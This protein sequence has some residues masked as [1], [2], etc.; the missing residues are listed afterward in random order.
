[1]MLFDP[2]RAE[3]RDFNALIDLENRTRLAFQKHSLDDILFGL[4]QVAD[5]IH[6]LRPFMVAGAASCAMRYCTAGHRAQTKALAW[7]KLRPLV[8]LSTQY[9]LADPICFDENL[10]EE[11]FNSNYIFL[12]LRTVGNQFPFEIEFSAHY[13][14]S[15]VLYAELPKQLER[16]KNVPKFDFGTEFFKVNG[17][18]VED[19]LA[20]GFVT[21]AFAR[22]HL[23]FTRGFYHKA[24]SSGC[25][26]PDDEE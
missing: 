26:I 14:R 18:P 17:L 19:F 7:E 15:M 4:H 24:R 6:T 13:A 1:M 10:R 22:A 20:L 23:G 12:M 9:L 21:F 5:T 8:E 2:K 16:K 3:I 25:K 11:F